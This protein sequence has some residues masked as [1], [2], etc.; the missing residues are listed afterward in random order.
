MKVLLISPCGLPIPAVQGGAVLTL[1]E[2]LVIQ[3][4]AKGI[5]D[6][7]IVGIY[8]KKAVEKAKMYPN[9]NFIFIKEPLIIKYLDNIYEIIYQI[10]SKKHHG[11]PKKYM[12][13]LFILKKLKKILLTELYDRIVFEN[14]GYLLN[15]LRD[16]Y[17]CKKYHGKLFYHI[18]NDIPNNIYVEGM[19]KC[20]CLLISEYLRQKIE[21][22]SNNQEINCKILQ[23]GFNVDYF[24]QALSKYDKEQ[25]R[26][27]LKIRKN[28]KIILYIGRID[29][30]KGI[31]ELVQAFKNCGRDD[32]VLLVVGSHCFGSNLTTPFEV[33]MK[34]LFDELGN[35]VV[36]TGFIPHYDV[37]KYYKIADVAVLPSMWNEP[38]GL[39]MIEAAAAGVPVITTNSGGIPEYLNNNY[40]ILLNREKNIEGQIANA[41]N[42]V[43]DN[44]YKWSKIAKKASLFVASHFSEETYYNTF[45][46]YISSF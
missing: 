45:V 15:I 23:N 32:S 30:A 10:I 44:E 3:N 39:T 21:S 27:T 26:A 14:A 41:I 19:K 38:A 22:L 2:S 25:L 33:R 40:A 11:N 46:N 24:T 29:P 5:L 4:E 28:K 6:L 37:W 17:V 12:F 20:T 8:D 1:I 35:K 7:S 9:T 16:C 31:E 42:E 34:K 36:S 18:H 13:K 43:L